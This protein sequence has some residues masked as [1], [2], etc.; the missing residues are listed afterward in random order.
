MLRGEHGTAAREALS[1]QLEVGRFFNARRF[2]P[3]TNAHMMGDIEV[4]GDGGLAWLRASAEGRARCAVSATTNARCVDSALLEELG[5]DAEEAAKEAELIGLLRSMG[6]TTTD[7]CINYQTVYQPHFGERVAWS[8]TGA[9]IY[10]NSVFGARTNFEAGP[11]ALAAAITRRVPEYGF[12]LDEHR[13]GTFLVHVDATPED[14]AD[15]GA[16]GKLVGE[17]RPGY[18]QVPVF[19]GLP[20][21][22]SSDQLKHL[23]AALASYGTMAMFHVVGVTP[24]A[25]TIEAALGGRPPDDELTVTDEQLDDVYRLF[26]PEPTDCHLVVFSAPQLSLWEVKR[27][28]EL[29][30]STATTSAARVFVTTEAGTLANAERLGYAAT[31]RQ[32][33]VTMMAGVCFYILLNLPDMRKRNGWTTLVTNSAKLTNVIGAHGFKTV[34]RKTNVCVEAAVS[35]RVQ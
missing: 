3:V 1:L 2:V 5:Q 6:V 28:S 31:L 10:A 20:Q 23:G 15:W 18:F 7:T 26:L 35:G 33:G 21:D 14:V 30:A 11:A 13:R 27:V 12:Q 24:E 8:D 17:H 4:M 22:V 9:V 29:F 16:L 34:L 32:A 19:T 25:P